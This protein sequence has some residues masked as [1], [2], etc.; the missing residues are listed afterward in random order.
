MEVNVKE[1]IKKE[2][3]NL[4]IPENELNLLSDDELKQ[5]LAIINILLN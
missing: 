3:L 4:G 2:L 5:K 1:E